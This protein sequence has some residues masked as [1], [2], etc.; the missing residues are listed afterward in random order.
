MGIDPRACRGTGGLDRPAGYRD[1]GCVSRRIV[2]VREE[3]EDRDIA[4]WLPIARRGFDVSVVATRT[5]STYAGTGLGLP[6]T[7]TRRIGDLCGR[8]P[9]A[10]RAERFLSHAVDPGR[11]LRL[12]RSLRA[13]DVVCVN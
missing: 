3:L 4:N 1:G 2:L 9:V 13:A 8:G 6:V 7:H 11:A 5:S 12:T 10:R